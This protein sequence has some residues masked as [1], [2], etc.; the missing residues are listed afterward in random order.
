MLKLSIWLNRRHPRVYKWIGRNPALSA[1]ILVAIPHALVFAMVPFFGFDI[2]MR[3]LGV[4]FL[5]ILVAAIAFRN[6]ID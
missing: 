2:T 5:V 1:A 3:I 6:R 4:V